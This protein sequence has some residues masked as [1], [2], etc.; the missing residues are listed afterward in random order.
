MEKERNRCILTHEIPT[1]HVPRLRHLND[2]HIFV[3]CDDSGSMTKLVEGTSLTRWDALKKFVRLV[4]EISTAFNSHGICLRFLNR[5]CFEVVTQQSQVER[6]FQRAPLGY[7][8]LTRTLRDVLASRDFQR[9][10][11]NFLIFIATDGVP[12]TE[13]GDPDLLQ[14]KK[15]MEEERDANHTHVMFLICTDDEEVVDYLRSWDNR[16]TNVDVRLSI[17]AN[18]SSKKI[19]SGL[20][21][22][23]CGLRGEDAA[24]CNLS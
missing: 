19:W 23:I 18:R 13:D 14:F 2:F 6:L 7:T 16:M 10:D 1:Q 21:I 11:E 15:V 4:L 17:T 22:H 5:P 3:I 9:E 20:S 12:T 24:R 8:P